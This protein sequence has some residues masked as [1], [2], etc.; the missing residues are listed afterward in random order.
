MDAKREV[1]VAE[2]LFAYRDAAGWSQSETA[3]RAGVSRTSVVLTETGETYPRLPTLRR[4]ARAFGVSVDEFL[5]EREPRPLVEAPDLIVSLRGLSPEDRRLILRGLWE[6]WTADA[7]TDAEAMEK[8]AEF[9]R[10]TG[11]NAGDVRRALVALDPLEARR[12]LA[13]SAEHRD[14]VGRYWQ[15]LLFRAAAAGDLSADEAA[16]KAEAFSGAA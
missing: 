12:L 2:R 13:Q 3:R 8:A 1:D 7:R 11:A 6:E 9:E 5:S 4:L 15:R 14:E 10:E 16:S